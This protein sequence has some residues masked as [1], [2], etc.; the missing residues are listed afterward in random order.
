MFFRII[1]T[2][3]T[4][5]YLNLLSFGAWGFSFFQ[6]DLHTLNFRRLEMNWEK[7]IE[8]MINIA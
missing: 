8:I 7:I 5:N 4:F 1:W 3:P 2:V 6:D